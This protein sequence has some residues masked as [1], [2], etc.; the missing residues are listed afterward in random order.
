MDYEEEKKS[1]EENF[2]KMLATVHP[3][4]WRIHS[5]LKST[6]LNPE[7]V[8]AILQAIYEVAYLHGHGAVSVYI[9]GDKVTNVE[10]TTRIKVG[11][12]AIVEAT[13]V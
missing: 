11:M 1:N 10:A 3:N 5:K 9:S 13:E 6:N 8:P 4:L 12:S 7:I 2:D